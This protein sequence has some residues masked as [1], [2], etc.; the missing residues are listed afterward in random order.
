MFNVL[1]DS[2]VDSGWRRSRET[3][4][5]KQ[6]GTRFLKPQDSA[7]F[8]PPRNLQAA[9]FA[10]FAS[11]RASL[12]LTTAINAGL[13][14]VCAFIV[15]QE[16][17]ADDVKTALVAFGW[18]LERSASYRRHCSNQTIG[19]A[20]VDDGGA[21]KRTRTQILE[22]R[23]ALVRNGLEGHAS[24]FLVVDSR[25]A[26]SPGTWALCDHVVDVNPPGRRH[27]AAACR[28]LCGFNP[29]EELL[30]GL[31][32][33][34]P[35]DLSRVLRKGR[36]VTQIREHVARLKE[37]LAGGAN[38][39]NKVPLLDRLPGMPEATAWGR[40]L[41][42]DLKDWQ[43][44]TLPWSAIDRGAVLYG[45]PGTGKTTFVK[46]L[47]KTA[48]V[49]LV[50]TSLAQWQATGHLGDLLKAMF[51]D[52]HQARLQTPSILFIDELDAIG[53]RAKARGD[54]AQYQIEVINGLLE[55][56]DGVEGR[57]GVVVV[58][59]CNDPHRIDPAILR[60]G[61]LDRLIEIPP[62]DEESRAAILRFHLGT[63][64][65]DSDLGVFIDRADGFIDRADGLVGADLERI[66]REAR[67]RARRQRRPLRLDDLVAGLPSFQSMSAD[68]QYR[69]A[70][71]EAGHA[72]L[73]HLTPGRVLE[74][75]GIRR[76]YVLFGSGPQ[77]GGSTAS[78]GDGE[79]VLATER[80]MGRRL[81]ILLAGLA[82]EE[83]VLGCRSSG[84]GGDE[85]SD[86]GQATRLAAEME[87]SYGLGDSLICLGSGSGND[88]LRAV[89]GS[90][91]VRARVEARLRT[92]FEEAKAIVTGHLS[93]VELLAKTLVDRGELTGDEVAALF[94]SGDGGAEVDSGDCRRRLP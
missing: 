12:R 2:L 85:R 68:D 15:S 11:I 24:L 90:P 10:L 45:R 82:A 92:A 3:T 75:T 87:T 94:E 52:F 47:A 86:L 71:H 5:R 33:L 57:E 69:A 16:I 70:V 4:S 64:L 1:R 53:D 38:G 91:A 59:A 58:G 21:G 56:L 39:E 14:V 37:V 66:V 93:Q 13:P 8:N 50:A 63:D 29:A 6:I 17:A 88:L 84:A 48:G 72:L 28:C 77:A 22:A 65:P 80:E 31:L 7:I 55:N 78:R 83:L 46:S 23:D 74:R 32:S 41:A 54:N 61:R 44:G 30:D 62:P 34:A 73:I 81:S 49:K 40:D 18:C 9:P 89:Q 76:E 60:S 42:A 25:E 51:R 35:R 27:I 67:R 20:V 36:T 79:S 19:V 26:L 43:A